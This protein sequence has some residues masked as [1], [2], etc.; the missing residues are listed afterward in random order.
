M[1]LVLSVHY[2]RLPFHEVMHVILRS[3]AS[4]LTLRNNNVM[5]YCGFLSF[6]LFPYLHPKNLIGLGMSGMAMLCQRIVD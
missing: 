1:Y 4:A 2:T 6:T 3:H 5:Q